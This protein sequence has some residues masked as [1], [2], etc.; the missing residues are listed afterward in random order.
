MNLFWLFFIV[1][2][3]SM[4]I[5]SEI[6]LEEVFPENVLES[7]HMEVLYEFYDEL[8]D[9]LS[10]RDTESTIESL[11]ELLNSSGIVWTVLNYAADHENV[12]DLLTNY[13]GGFLENAISGNK[14]ESSDNSGS[15]IGNLVSGIA[16]TVDL[17]ALGNMVL[18][19]GLV[20]SLLDGLLLDE[21]FRPHLSDIIYN[22]VEKNMNL[23][24]IIANNLLKPAQN[25]E[26]LARD[27]QEHENFKR[28][29]S[30]SIT[31]LIGNLGGALLNSQLFYSGLND[32]LIALNDT[33]FL[34]YTVQKFLSTPEYLNLTGEL[35]TQTISKSG[36]NIL[37]LQSTISSLA[38]RINIT[39]IV[40][41]ALG[42]TQAITSLL[43]SL[44][45]GEGAQLT[46]F[47]KRYIPGIKAIV[48]DLEDKGLFV[49]LNNRLFPSS[50]PSSTSSASSSNK[51][52]ENTEISV[53]SDSGS[54]STF[55]GL[56]LFQT[57][58][59]SLLFFI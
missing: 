4:I 15:T 35:L 19:S 6:D 39:E 16:D 22:V 28:A 37:T 41:G 57:I 21:N 53:I 10:K 29:L 3:R 17:G 24:A 43:G 31:Q 52:A 26:L 12:I 42:D 48:N 59:Y 2:V 9:K 11:I 34:V 30:D 5:P 36:I 47:L 56:I 50:S 58:V 40:A 23:I 44:L 14:T 1:C 38:S 18:D 49:D 55:N 54:S 32:T 20:K 45:S 13:T 51:K 46:G 27:L 33:N 7:E 8:Q 25:K